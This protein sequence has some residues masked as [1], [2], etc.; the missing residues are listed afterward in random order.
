MTN[1]LTAKLTAKK[2]IAM[3]VLTS[4]LVLIATVTFWGTFTLTVIIINAVP[5]YGLAR[6]YVPAIFSAFITGLVAIYIVK[7]SEENGD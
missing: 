6:S 7:E 4:L 1:K 5:I 3:T 2:I